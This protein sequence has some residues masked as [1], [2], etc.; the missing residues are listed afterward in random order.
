M[1]YNQIEVY[2]SEAVKASRCYFFENWLMKHKWVT[3]VI[4]QAV[5]YHRNSQ[6]FYP[7]EPF[8]KKT[9]H[10]ET[11]CNSDVPIRFP[12]HK[13]EKLL[14]YQYKRNPDFKKSHFSFL[15]RE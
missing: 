12:V 11:P 2:L 15:N 13:V 10:Y 5:I 7:S 8:Q 3:L 1:K 14:S 4:I 6:C 9:Y